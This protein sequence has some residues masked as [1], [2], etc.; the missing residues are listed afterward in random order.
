VQPFLNSQLSILNLSK[1]CLDS[2]GLFFVAGLVQ[3]C[4]HILLVCFHTRLV[5]RIDSQNI[6]AD[7]ASYFKEVEQTSD[8]F[9]IQCRDNDAG[10]D[11]LF[12]SM[13]ALCDDWERLQT[14][15]DASNSLRHKD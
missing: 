4:K 6:T 9:F 5:E 11:L 10:A 13:Q 7:T 8:A 15:L 3:Q 14:A 2:F 12:P 1:S